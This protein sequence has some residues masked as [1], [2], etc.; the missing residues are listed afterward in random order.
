[1]RGPSCTVF[2]RCITNRALPRRRIVTLQEAFFSDTAALRVAPVFD[3]KG[4]ARS[5]H[6]M[7]VFG[8]PGHQWQAKPES[9]GGNQAIG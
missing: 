2:G 6:R 4:E 7:K 8:I 1:M 5:L 3:T 9:H